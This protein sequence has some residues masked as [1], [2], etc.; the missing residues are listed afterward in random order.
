M[1]DIKHQSFRVSSTR[2]LNR[3]SGIQELEKQ[4]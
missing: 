1:E 3:E 2:N 4:L